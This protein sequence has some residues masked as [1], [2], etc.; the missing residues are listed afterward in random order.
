MATNF[1]KTFAVFTYKCNGDKFPANPAVGYVTDGM[2]FNHDAALKE[3]AHEFICNT[4][5]HYS[6]I[7]YD[8]SGNNT[9]THHIY[10]L[11]ALE[12]LLYSVDIVI[13]FPMKSTIKVQ[14]LGAICGQLL[15]CNIT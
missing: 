4:N 7:V 10:I 3:N 9:I 8:I 15:M 12:T 6:R 1:H 2:A 5:E 13:P 11:S 14:T